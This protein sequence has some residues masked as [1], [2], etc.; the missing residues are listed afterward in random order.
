MISRI[1][2]N[3][4]PKQHL[5]TDFCTL[6]LVREHFHKPC[7]RSGL[8]SVVVVVVAAAAAAAAVVVVV[9]VVVVMIILFS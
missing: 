2:S 4:F 5:T 6:I 8:N 3:C 9:V 7:Q 1:N